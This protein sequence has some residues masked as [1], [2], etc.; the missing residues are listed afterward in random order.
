MAPEDIWQCLETFLVL[1]S[2]RRERVVLLAS[3]WVE[4]R[5]AAEHCEMPRQPPTAK[6]DLTLSVSS[7]EVEK[8]WFKGWSYL[9]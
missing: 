7:T 5:G 2:A 6:N 8:P 1:T 9:Q 4:V 3:K